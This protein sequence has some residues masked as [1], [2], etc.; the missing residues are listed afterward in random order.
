M[1]RIWSDYCQFLLDQCLITRT[2]KACDKA[3]QSL[4]ITQHHRIWPIYLSLVESF[5]IPDT[6]VKVY[7]RYSKL[8][9]ETIEDHANYLKKIGLIDE[10]AHKYLFMLNNEDFVSKNSK[11]KH[12]VS[13][14][15][16]VIRS[17][18]SMERRLD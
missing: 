8:M 1:P 13:S 2:R 15:K 7:R 5:D 3:L 12:Q 6:G 10:C 17:E 9:P 14:N 11:T 4:P 18:I 16:E